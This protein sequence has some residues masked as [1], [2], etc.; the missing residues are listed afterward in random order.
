MCQRRWANDLVTRF[1]RVVGERGNHAVSFADGFDEI[2]EVQCS[3]YSKSIAMIY[4]VSCGWRPTQRVCGVEALDGRSAKSS[5]RGRASERIGKMRGLRRKPLG[6]IATE[7][8][9]SLSLT[10][11][12]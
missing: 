3:Q 6:L 2:F 7:H 10:L 9:L 4:V 5:A 12:L 8:P 1:R 11:D